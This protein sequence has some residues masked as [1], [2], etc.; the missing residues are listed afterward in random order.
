MIERKI[1]D[2]ISDLIELYRI[3]PYRWKNERFAH[4]D[5]FRIL[6]DYFE[7]D[8]IRN[9]F[10]WEYP[11]GVPS[12]GSGRKS[13]AID[14]VYEV[15]SEKWIAIEIE[16]TGA[17]KSLEEELIKCIAKLK[18]SPECKKHMYVG[19]IIPLTAREKHKR[20]RGYGKS[21]EDL[22][23]ETVN[24]AKERIGDNP[25]EIITDGILLS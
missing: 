15:D 22:L 20:A 3:D 21:Y 18:S 1:R 5:F 23:K 6:F 7:P 10:R 16:L 2:A 24:R 4:Y 25:I 11:V 17:G 9:Y 14:I 12:Y 19:F 8:E 13:A